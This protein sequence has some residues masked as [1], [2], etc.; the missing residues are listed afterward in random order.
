MNA[1]TA[2]EL[3][4][5][6]PISLGRYR[7]YHHKY[8]TFW[9]AFTLGKSEVPLLGV[10]ASLPP[11]E[12]RTAHER[13]SL[14]VRN[15]SVQE[16]E[17]TLWDERLI[18]ATP[19]RWEILMHEE[20]EGNLTV[21]AH[22]LSYGFLQAEVQFLYS[23]FADNMYIKRFS[24]PHPS[25]LLAMPRFTVS[26][27][28]LQPTHPDCLQISEAGY[29][30]WTLPPANLP[31]QALHLQ[32]RLQKTVDE[33]HAVIEHIEHRS[34]LFPPGTPTLP[35]LKLRA[36]AQS[37]A[38]LLQNAQWQSHLAEDQIVLRIA[39]NSHQ[40]SVFT[41]AAAKALLE[42]SRFSGDEPAKWT[43]R[44]AMNSAMEFQVVNA[45]NSNSGACW[46]TVDTSKQGSDITGQRRF[47]LHR[48]ARVL[49]HTLLLHRDTGSE[50]CVRVALNGIS[51][52][53]LKRGATGIYDG[54]FVLPDGTVQGGDGKGIMGAIISV[55]CA[56]YGL[57]ET[58]AY[59]HAANRLAEHL[60]QDSCT[61]L[62]PGSVLPAELF[63]TLR[64]DV[65]AA[66]SAIEALVRLY[67][68]YPHEPLREGALRM[69]Q[70][71]RSWQLGTALQAYGEVGE[72]LAGDGA[73]AGYVDASIEAARGAL[74]AFS[75]HRDA[76]WFAYASQA[77]HAAARHLDPLAGFPDAK[78]AYPDHTYALATF[79]RAYLHWLLSIPTLAPGVECDPDL[80]LC[81]AGN[82]IFTPE[83]S[84]WRTIHVETRGLVDWVA[85]VCP[86][87]HDILL[88]VLTDGSSATASVQA[89]EHRRMAT[90]LIGGD[91]SG[92]YP[93][94]AVPGVGSVGVYILQA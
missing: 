24:S 17:V 69:M 70:W 52:L 20:D 30:T 3:S 64:D 53:L 43:A 18:D 22:F 4:V 33:E 35:S 77:L 15:C 81:R 11:I 45:Q 73:P 91:T 23:F 8:G 27:F 62:S 85:L 32:I 47:S 9:I 26:I 56:A 71:L 72:V 2:S 93:L 50:L 19:I 86:A 13:H 38:A 44:L 87:T 79:T 36:S 34:R 82:R 16:G 31:Q 7:L 92:I 42:W 94:H 78:L 21:Q 10:H 1:Q 51:W 55:M 6:L 57:T 41:L 88:A 84:L 66:S 29:L 28:T 37:A 89:G 83:P 67:R 61:P 60:L 49:Q 59:M 75:L 74:W 14:F 65:F 12:L 58:E 40:F 54:A 63:P 90:D 80:L 46:D 5:A 76:L 48:N 39:P 25:V 68:A